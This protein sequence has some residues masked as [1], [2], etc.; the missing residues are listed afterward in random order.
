MAARALHRWFPALAAMI[1]LPAM[2]QDSS[3]FHVGGCAEIYY[4]YDF[5][6]PASGE[7]PS[8]LY[9]HKRHNEVNVNLAFFKA[10]F[11][12]DRTRANLAL[13]AGTYP[14]YNLAAE[15]AQLQNIMEANVGVKLSPGRE[16]WLDAGVL[17]SH[18]G[19]ESAIGSDCATLTRSLWAENTPYFETGA[20]LSYAPND[21]LSIAALYLNGWQR[22]QRQPGNTAPNFGTQVTATTVNGTTLNWSTFIGSDTPDS[23]GLWRYYNNVYASFDGDTTGLTLGFDLGLQEDPDGGMDGWFGPV[24]VL[25]QRVGRGWWCNGRLEFFND[26]GRVIMPSDRP[27]MSASLGADKWFTDHVVWRVE[28]RWIG[29]ENEIFRTAEGMPTMS[30]WAITTVLCARF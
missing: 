29:N 9:N 25:R 14:Q 4:S 10:A 1:R 5:S 11:A 23:V 28:A 19:F 7:R 18:I 16:L 30:N 6:E 8:F 3:D 24:V 26:E 15:P 12:R 21:R 27:M 2:A 22:I 17:P 20:R 13:M